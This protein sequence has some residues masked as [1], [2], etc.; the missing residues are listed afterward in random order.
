M[1]SWIPEMLL[2]KFFCR[3]LAGLAPADMGLFTGTPMVNDAAL[4]MV[5]RGEAEWLR[6]DIKGFT[7]DGVKLIVRAKGVPAGG[8]GKERTIKGDIVVMAT[9]FKRP[10][11]EFLPEDNFEEPY[12]PPNWY[13]QTFPPNHPSVCCNNCTYVNAIGSVGNWHIGIYTRILI[14]FMLDDFARPSPF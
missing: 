8:P 3:D 9:G 2:R 4:E 7:K 13:L 6:G 14:V 1:F 10:S 12:S 11:L 5:R